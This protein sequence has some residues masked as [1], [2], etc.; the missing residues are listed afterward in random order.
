MSFGKET[1]T[2]YEIGLKSDLLGRRMRLN[3]AAFYLDYEDIQTRVVDDSGVNRV[4]NGPA[5]TSKGLEAELTFRATEGLSIK[6][7]GGYA[8]AT[9]DSFHNCASNSDCTGNQLPGASRWTATLGLSYTRT[10]LKDWDLLAGADYS[11]HSRMYQDARNLEATRLNAS[12][13]VDARLG[14][15]SASGN[16]GSD[17]V[18]Q[19]PVQP[20]RPSL[21]AG[22][23]NLGSVHQYRPVRPAPYLWGEFYLQLLLKK[24]A[25]ARF[26]IARP[27]IY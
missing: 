19:E 15:V 4:V 26:F 1:V 8:D 14:L 5:A 20:G 10:V 13:R 11:Y 22:C 16:L 17:V 23:G 12:N 21:S 3:L 2:S 6:A 27:A 18:G 7:S 9:F 24:R 25:T